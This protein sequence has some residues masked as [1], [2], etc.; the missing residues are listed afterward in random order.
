MMFGSN[1][2]NIH[3]YYHV[4]IINHSKHKLHTSSITSKQIQ[5]QTLSGQHFGNVLAAG[6]QQQH[7]LNLWKQ[8]KGFKIT[9][10]IIHI[11]IITKPSKANTDHGNGNDHTTNN[12]SIQHK[13]MVH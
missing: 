10:F 3:H 2:S 6:N 11:L 9:V 5:Q 1:N 4:L 13:F 8:Y 12:N 7:E